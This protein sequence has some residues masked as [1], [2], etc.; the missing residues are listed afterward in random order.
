M[1]IGYYLRVRTSLLR[2][3]Y[4]YPGPGVRCGS[5]IGHLLKVGSCFSE[6]PGRYGSQH[7]ANSVDSMED[8]SRHTVIVKDESSLIVDKST[9]LPEVASW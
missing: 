2:E 9:P 6:P 7:T 5:S 1:S 4:G 3:M 8:A